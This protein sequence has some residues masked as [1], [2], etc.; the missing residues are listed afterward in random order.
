MIPVLMAVLGLATVWGS[1]KT[2][3]SNHGTELANH[4]V[5]IT[6]TET[7]IDIL[8]EIVDDKMD[9][10]LKAQGIDYKPRKKVIRNE[11]SR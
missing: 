4:E 6:K 8:Y 2:E 1:T 3:I 7:R 10:L 11:P 9:A 5:R